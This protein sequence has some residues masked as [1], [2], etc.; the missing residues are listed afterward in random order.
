MFRKE[1]EITNFN[2]HTQHGYERRP[3]Q[4]DSNVNSSFQDRGQNSSFQDRGQNSSFQDRGQN[5]SFQDRGQNQP[6]RSRFKEFRNND[7]KRQEISQD[8]YNEKYGF[9]KLETSL[10]DQDNIIVSEEAVADEKTSFDDI[11][12][13]NGAEGLKEDLLCGI[14]GCGFDKTSKVQ[15][16][17]IPQI[18]K[19][20]E[21][22][23]QSHSGTGKTGAFAISALE[24]IDESL[25]ELQVIC[26]SPTH[27]LSQQTLI[28]FKKLASHMPNVR[29]S[30]TVGRTDRNQNLKELGH[31][32]K[33]NTAQISV[34]TPGR[35]LDLLSSNIK[36]FNSVKL[37]IID[38]CD[39]LLDG[40][41]KEGIKNIIEKLPPTI[42]IC[43]F[44]ATLNKEVVE[45]AKALL[46]EP[47]KILIKQ[48]K[49]SL[50]NIKQTYVKVDNE[51]QKLMVMKDMLTT[52]PIEQFIVYVNSK[53][54]SLWLKQMLE[55]EQITVLTI[56]GSQN[57]IERSDI[58]REFKDGKA[59]CLIATDLLSRG[60]DIQQLSL[61]INFDIP[62]ADN[63]PCYI[64]RIGRSG[65][66]DR[67]GFAISIVTE[68]EMHVISKL[69]LT[70][71]CSIEPLQEDFLKNF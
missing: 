21:I 66:Y 45:I 13:R 54:K 22:L 3:Q 2:K 18:I 56:N 50:K 20:K 57:K 52:L 28:V 58:L 23:A 1:G 61:V 31:N 47:I 35:L 51:E 40:T 60:I 33:E 68:N 25:N 36:L 48:E 15:G 53:K 62:R 30:F 37:V 71:N 43:L 46:H 38:E 5:S 11:G 49:M 17:A 59:K 39:E 67:A 69:A 34:C 32:N 26:I 55:N 41:F 44:S 70:Y 64:H 9:A 63:L 8:D 12:G 14:Y 7:Y 24:I 27:E 16:L 4:E 6:Q 10:L 42:Q 29:L 65:R 19:G